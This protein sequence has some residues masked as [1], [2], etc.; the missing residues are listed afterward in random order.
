MI[1]GERKQMTLQPQ[2]AY[3]NVRSKLIK[4][5]PRGRFKP[6]LVLSVGKRLAKVAARSGR[7]RNAVVV[8]L[9]PDAVV[10]DCNHPLAGKILEIELQLVSLDS[11][12]PAR[13][14]DENATS[15]N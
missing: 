5:I 15:L 2:D 12:V 8:G 7:R 9:T 11:S 3:G 4:Q 6:E 13:P 14:T 1:A 10:V